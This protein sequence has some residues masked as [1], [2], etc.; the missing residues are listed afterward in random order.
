MVSKTS[1]PPLSEVGSAAG[2][3]AA[4]AVAFMDFSPQPGKLVVAALSHLLTGVFACRIILCPDRY[5]LTVMLVK[6]SS[7]I[8]CC[9][10]LALAR[11]V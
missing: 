2:R 5:L 10:L 7:L 4:E 1:A 11:R 3:A 8:A 9:C 6:A